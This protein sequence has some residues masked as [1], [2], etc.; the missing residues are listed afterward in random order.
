MFMYIQL[1]FIYT[2]Y[3][4]YIYTLSITPTERQK[5]QVKKTEINQINLQKLAQGSSKD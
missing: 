1:Y 5:V 4:T 3:N 2:I